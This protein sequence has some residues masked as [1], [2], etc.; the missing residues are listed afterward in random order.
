MAKACMLCKRPLSDP[1]SVDR[2]LG[3]VCWAKV[4]AEAE[5]A[6]DEAREWQCLL[7]FE[8]N[9]VLKRENGRVL[10]NVPHT[11][12][13]HSPTGF[14]WGYGGSGPADLALNILL[15]YT[16]EEAADRLYQRFKWEF[17]SRVPPEG[18][19]IKGETIRA[20]LEEQ[21]EVDF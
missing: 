16:D 8:G 21:K 7:P 19:V 1:E 12:V 13:R 17:V 2:G 15:L 11:I 4:Q 5:R 9:V 3:P 6:E 20:W 18:G 14:A 10:T